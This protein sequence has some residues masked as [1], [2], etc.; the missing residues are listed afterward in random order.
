MASVGLSPAVAADRPPRVAHPAAATSPLLRM[1]RT[2]GNRAVALAVQRARC[3]CRGGCGSCSGSSVLGASTEDDARDA[4]QRAVSVQRAPDCT[5]GNSTDLTGTPWATMDPSLKSVLAASFLHRGD[6]TES[7]AWAYFGHARDDCNDSLAAA[8]DRHPPVFA[9]AIARV[10]SMVSSVD[11]ALWPFVKVVHNA[12]RTDNWGMGVAWTDPVKLEAH[13][14]DSPKFCKDNPISA[15]IFH[16]GAS[17][18]WRQ[19]ANG[20]PGLHVVVDGQPE[21]HIDMHQPTKGRQYWPTDSYCAWSAAALAG[22]AG[23]VF[24]GAGTPRGITRWSSDNVTWFNLKGALDAE[25]RGDADK[26]PDLAKLKEAADTLDALKPRMQSAAGQGDLD[27]DQSGFAS[28]DALEADPDVTGKLEG[29][30]TTLKQ[31][32]DALAARAAANIERGYG[33]GG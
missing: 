14:Q 8:L 23:D 33:G 29:V 10:G 30:E 2:V 3:G 7:L 24:G 6:D 19:V 21:I 16:H 32:R 9:A 27:S 15:M 22:H 25:P 18:A 20:K 31:L 17:N 1:Q 5:T 11:P 26:Q 28:D 12:W 13:L 4:V